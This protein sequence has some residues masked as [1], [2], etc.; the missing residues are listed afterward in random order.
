VHQSKQRSAFVFSRVF[1]ARLWQPSY[2]DR[3][4]R[5]GEASLSVARYIFDNPVVGGLVKSPKDYP[6]LGS[7]RYSVNEILEAVAWQP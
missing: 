5:D 4:L 1:G 3:I 2:Y 7:E 6:F